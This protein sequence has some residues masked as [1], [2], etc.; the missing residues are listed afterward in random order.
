MTP[1][2]YITKFRMG[3]ENYEFS[4]KEFL[5]EF[6]KDFLDSFQRLPKLFNGSKNGGIPTYTLF[7]WLIGEFHSKFWKISELKPG[8]NLTK[9]LWGAFY[10][11]TIIPT[12]EKYYPDLHS[13]ILAKRNN[14]K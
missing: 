6:S 11:I 10:A 7:R 4:R 12:R 1:N 2:E 14:P 8:K 5:Q 9:D 13:K 3:Q